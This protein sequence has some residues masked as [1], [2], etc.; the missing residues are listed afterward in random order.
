M[1]DFRRRFSLTLGLWVALGFSFSFIR[2]GKGTPETAE[3]RGER[4]T[5]RQ[6]I[7][8]LFKSPSVPDARFAR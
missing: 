8:R 7:W 6:R 3:E 4:A 5:E 2:K 1:M